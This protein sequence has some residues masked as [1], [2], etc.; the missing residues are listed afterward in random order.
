MEKL[1]ELVAEGREKQKLNEEKADQKFL[2]DS[3]EAKVEAREIY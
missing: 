2:K 3:A 1:K